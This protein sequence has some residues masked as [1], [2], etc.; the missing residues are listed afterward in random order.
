MKAL[1]VIWSRYI[2]FDVENNDKDLNFKVG[3]YKRISKFK[4]FFGNITN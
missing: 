4:N 2:D 3:N 1:N